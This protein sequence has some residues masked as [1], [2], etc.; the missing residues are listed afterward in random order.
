[1]VT[2]IYKCDKCGV[3]QDNADQFWTVGVTA[4]CYGYDA[5]SF[6]RDKSLQVCRPCLELLGIHVMEKEGETLPTPPT[7]EELIREIILRCS[8]A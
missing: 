8:N 7:V 6:L 5:S 4:M 2:I 1:M 3:N